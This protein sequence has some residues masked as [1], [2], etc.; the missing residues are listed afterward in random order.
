MFRSPRK[1]RGKNEFKGGVVAFQFRLAWFCNKCG[2]PVLVPGEAKNHPSQC[3]SI[4]GRAA[5]AAELRK[6]QDLEARNR[7]NRRPSARRTLDLTHFQR[8]AQLFRHAKQMSPPAKPGS[9]YRPPPQDVGERREASGMQRSTPTPDW[10][11][12]AAVLY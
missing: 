7:K 10:H 2:A 12:H 6:I 9:A 8:A 5:R 3:P 11:Q 1:Q 4:Y